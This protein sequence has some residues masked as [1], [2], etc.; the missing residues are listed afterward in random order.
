L[1]SLKGQLAVPDSRYPRIVGFEVSALSLVADPDGE[2]VIAFLDGV[3]SA[4][5]PGVFEQELRA[6]SDAAHI[7]RM[8]LENDRLLLFG[9]TGNV[10]QVCVRVRAL[11]THISFQQQEKLL[12]GKSVSNDS[13]GADPGGTA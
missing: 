1:R 4:H 3:P 6:L 7:A 5:W 12:G 11:A 8:S 13:G 10:R 2:P 9:V